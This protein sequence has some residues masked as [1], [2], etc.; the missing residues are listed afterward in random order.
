[1]A[2][3]IA[4]IHGD[5]LLRSNV[6]DRVSYFLETYRID[7]PTLNEAGITVDQHQSTRDVSGDPM[8]SAQ[9]RHIWREQ[10]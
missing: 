7:V 8:R 6:E 10:R 3:G 2:P 9:A 5:Q 1:M 4:G